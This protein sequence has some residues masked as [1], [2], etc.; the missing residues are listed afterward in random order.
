MCLNSQ[1]QGK[2]ISIFQ[3]LLDQLLHHTIARVKDKILVKVVIDSLRFVAFIIVS[4]KH[5][6]MNWP[7]FTTVLKKDLTK[8]MEVWLCNNH[9]FK[10]KEKF[11]LLQMY[12]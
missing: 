8:V 1:A 11:H 2:D 4:P 6:L 7:Y 10:F 3:R 9:S 5:S 12:Y